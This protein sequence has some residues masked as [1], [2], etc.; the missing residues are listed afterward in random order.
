MRPWTRMECA[1]LLDESSSLAD[2]GSPDEASRLYAVLEKEFTPEMERPNERFV[3]VDSIYAR[4]TG[5]ASL[6][7]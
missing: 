6:S 7:L 4:A 2:E 1:R 5:I 3:Q